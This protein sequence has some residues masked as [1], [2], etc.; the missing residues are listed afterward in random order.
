MKNLLRILFAVVFVAASAGHAWAWGVGAWGTGVSPS[1]TDTLTNKTLDANGTG[2]TIKGYGYIILGNPHLAGSGVAA[3]MDTT[4]TNEYYGQATFDDAVDVATN[5]VEYRLV[6]PH[7]FDSTVDLYAY[8]KFRLGG[9]DTADHDYVISC[10]SVAD[11]GD[12]TGSLGDAVN[13]AYTA[14]GS[15]AD[16]DV[17]TASGTLTGWAAAITAGQ[18]LV[19]RLARDGD[20][21]TNDASTVNSYTGPLVIR[22]GYS[23]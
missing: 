18:L 13:L 2:N 7:D 15:G 17:E 5:Y 1:S 10:D 21:G 16:G 8:F 20:D 3:S 4:A 22:Y 11:S 23:Q 14:D 19:I 6:V 9:T 12:Y